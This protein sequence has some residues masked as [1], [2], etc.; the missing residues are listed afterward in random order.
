MSIAVVTFG[1]PTEAHGPQR[2][3][4]RSEIHRENRPSSVLADDSHPF[5]EDGTLLVLWQ[6]RRLAMVM[7]A[8]RSADQPPAR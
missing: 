8:A 4:I 6:N 1:V 5:M 3:L 7:P 2:W